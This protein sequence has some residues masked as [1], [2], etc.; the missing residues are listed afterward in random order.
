MSAQRAFLSNQQEANTTQ[1]TKL[2]NIN[3]TLRY[4]GDNSFEMEDSVRYS[5]DASF[6]H[7][8]TLVF[9]GLKYE[10]TI[11]PIVRLVLNVTRSSLSC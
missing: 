10:K 11:T 2:C 3:Q 6:E 7:P 5:C 9:N 1:Q 8:S 4:Y